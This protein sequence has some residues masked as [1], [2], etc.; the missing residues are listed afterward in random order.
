M[1]FLL[2]SNALI[3]AARPDARYAPFRLWVKHSAAVVSAIS[4]VE[5]LGF[6]RL[7][8]ADARAFAAMFLLLPQLPITDAVLD[9]AVKIRQ[10]TRLK[11]PDALVAATALVHGLEL[12]TADSDFS[13]VAGLVVVNPLLG[14]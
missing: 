7:T 14:A 9:Q 12:V 6:T 4:R 1:K 11:T 13:R 2:D 3:Y 5:V 10:Q 8:V